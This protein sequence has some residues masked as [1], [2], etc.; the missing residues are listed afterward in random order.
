[1]YSNDCLWWRWLVYNISRNY[2][3][4]FDKPMMKTYVCD[5]KIEY[6]HADVFAFVFEYTHLS[7]LTL[8]F[9][10]SCERSE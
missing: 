4:E 6:A 8:N 2:R 9:A 1:M 3:V 7:K 10:S 5:S